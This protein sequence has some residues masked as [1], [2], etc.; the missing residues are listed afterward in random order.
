MN[1]VHP[2]FRSI[3]R[4]I[5]PREVPNED[6]TEPSHDETYDDVIKPMTVGGWPRSHIG[7]EEDDDS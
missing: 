7:K 5:A 4:P 3:L 2:I 1:N 6:P